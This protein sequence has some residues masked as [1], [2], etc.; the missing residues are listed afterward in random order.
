[1]RSWNRCRSDKCRDG[2]FS[3]LRGD[4][5]WAV[6]VFETLLET[7]G[8]DTRSW[9]PWAA[10]QVLPRDAAIGVI[11][12][13]IARERLHD[14]KDGAIGELLSVDP[15][16]VRPLL[17]ELRK[18]L[19]ADDHSQTFVLWT[20]AALDDP[21]ALPSVDRFLDRAKRAGLAPYLISTGEVV[22]MV[23]AHR[24]D[25]IFDLIR[26]HEHDRMSW[27]TNAARII[28]TPVAKEVLERCATTAPDVECRM[29]CRASLLRGPGWD[30]DEILIRQALRDEFG[31]E[32]VP[33]PPPPQ[34]HLYNE[35]GTLKEIY[36]LADDGE[37]RV[38]YERRGGVAGVIGRFLRRGD[39]PT[40]DSL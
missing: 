22:R 7:G 18:R 28:D 19:A 5:T 12:K 27:L 25:E 32:A 40:G 31:P 36:E 29:E 14:Y 38:L 34:V 33:D 8:A 16:A 39:P 10:R 11:R 21:E 20:L 13:A 23:L 2:I 4:T 26:G 1:M 30:H 6:H 3:E 37:R 35:R 15:E 9:V 17:P 24:Y